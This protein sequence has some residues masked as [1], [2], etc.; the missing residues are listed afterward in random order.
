MP[1]HTIH[2]GEKEAQI[3]EVCKALWKLKN[4]SDVVNRII[5]EYA[6]GRSITKMIKE[7]GEKEK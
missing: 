5:K 3:I 2:F 4:K 6:D 7:K 1:S